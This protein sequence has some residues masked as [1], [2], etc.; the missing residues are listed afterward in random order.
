MGNSA[1]RALALIGVLGTRYHLTQGKVRDLLAQVL[2][3]D[4]SVGT[5]SQAHAKVALA[6]AA[7]VREAARTLPQAPVKNVD[8]TRYPREGSTGQWVWGV[9]TPQ[10]VV[11]NLLPSRARYV[12]HSL[13]GETPKGIVIT[14]R[15]AA[16]AHIPA[17]Q[18][19][20]CWAHLL[21]DFARISERCGL[22]GRIGAKL[23]GAGY[24]LFRWRKAGKPAQAFEPLQRRIRRAL[25]Q[26]AEQTACRRT[27]G[28]CTQLLKSWTSLWTFLRRADVAP[29]N[30]DAERALRAIVV[31]RKISGPTRSRRGDLFIARGFSVIE[32]CRRQGRD[33]FEYLQQA[34]SA[35]LHN[36]PAP[37]LVPAAVPSG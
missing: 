17:E 27:A 36:V 31:K 24:V 32:T 33:A 25:E 13:L 21:R 10:V 26:G 28:T 9:V 22:P 1:P 20:L 7:P 5:V 35:W 29:T 23:L 37:S 16:Y 4:F 8:E 3:L 19:Q 18:R 34:V 6:L 11:F 30:N 12:I 14:D 15:Y 2:G